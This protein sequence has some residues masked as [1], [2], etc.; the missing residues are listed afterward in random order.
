MKNDDRG[1][2]VAFSHDLE[3]IV[4]PAG[5]A[6]KIAEFGI[7]LEDA[8]VEQLGK[9]L[10]ALMDVNTRTNL[11]AIRDADEA[12][13][14]H[15]FDALTLVPVL[16]EMPEADGRKRVID[17]G[18]GGGLPGIP[19]AI[20]MPEIDFVLLDA[21]KRKT[22]FIENCVAWLGL[23]NVTVI[24]GR[25]EGVGQDKGRKLLQGY[26]GGHREKYDGA[27]ARA[28]GKV[29]M[30]AELTV[31]LVKVGGLV[32][33]TKGEKADEEVTDAKKALHMLHTHHVGTIET[34]TGRVVVLEKRRGTPK[35][36]PRRDGE[37][38]RVPLGIT[39][40]KN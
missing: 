6:G 2:P 7:G 25:A 34:P 21:T 40:G 19:L 10:A 28:V 32:F 11:T 30:I 33:L 26:T 16:G 22:D 31:P 27:M 14:R 17:V 24:N 29:A 18:S 23:T 3:A 39:G 13:D 36:Y 4:P 8:E 35:M 20:A 1:N 12:W 5:W 37:P 15:I 9:Y 38:K